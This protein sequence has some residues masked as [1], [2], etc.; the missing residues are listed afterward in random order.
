MIVHYREVGDVCYIF[1]H[2]ATIYAFYFVMVCLL[3][4]SLYF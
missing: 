3:F 1:H 2:A 4:L